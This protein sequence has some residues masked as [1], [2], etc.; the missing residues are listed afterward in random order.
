MNTLTERDWKI[1]KR[2]VYP[3]IQFV[4]QGN[5]IQIQSMLGIAIEGEEFYLPLI[6]ISTINEL[7]DFWAMT[8]EYTKI[9]LE[10]VEKCVSKEINIKEDKNTYKI[11][12]E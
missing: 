6:K 1:M 4:S 3:N 9:A 12:K 11:V 7:S 8:E 5:K 2:P 10:L